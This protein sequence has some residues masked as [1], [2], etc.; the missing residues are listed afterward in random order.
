MEGQEE[1]GVAQGASVG[2][3]CLSFNSQVLSLK[4]SQF[5]PFSL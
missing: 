4:N 1:T 3:K 5:K 2:S